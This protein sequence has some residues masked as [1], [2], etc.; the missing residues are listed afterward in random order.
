LSW[1]LYPLLNYVFFDIGS[2]TLPDR[3]ISFDGGGAS[4]KS[5]FTD[6]TIPGGTIDKYYHVL[7]IYGFRLNQYPD[8]K[9]TLIG[10]NDNTNDGEKG[11]TDLSKSRAQTVYD[12][13]NKVWGI[14]AD[15]M[16]IEFRNFPD[17][18]S[19][20]KDSMGLA[21]NRRVEL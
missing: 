5:S 6:T 16:K 4:F 8:T 10:C 17:I 2:S 14:S 7:N 20:P 11:N 9:I 18:K 3:Y 13:L 12:Y 19:N 1:D 15:R 21:E